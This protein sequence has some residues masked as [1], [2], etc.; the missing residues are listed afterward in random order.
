MGNWGV[1]KLDLN[2]DGDF[3][4]T[5][6]SNDDRTHNKANEL[7]ARDTDDNGTD[8]FT[9][10]FDALGNLTDDAESYEYEYDG[11]GRL[12]K[13]KDASDSS[14]IAE[15]RYNG[16]GHLTALHE[17][18]DDDSD[19]DTNDTWFYRMLNERW[20]WVA[21]IR[22][23]D[24][25]PKEEFVSHKGGFAAEHTLL[26]DLPI[27]NNRDRDTSWTDASDQDL[28]SRTF[29]SHNRHSDLSA[30]ISDSGHMVEW[31]SY[32]GFSDSF[33]IPRGDTDSDGVTDSSDRTNIDNWSAGYDVRYD[34]NLSGTIDQ[35][36]STAATD[37][38]LGRGATSS[39]G[40]RVSYSAYST[41]AHTNM[42]LAR[43]RVTNTS[44]GTWITRDPLFSGDSDYLSFA[45]AHTHVTD[46]ATLG[47]RDHTRSD[48][49]NLYGYVSGRFTVLTDPFGLESADCY[50]LYTTNS[51]SQARL[52]PT[53]DL[54]F[55][56]QTKYKCTYTEWVLV[57]E[58]CSPC[59]QVCPKKRYKKA[60]CPANAFVYGA[61][62]F[63]DC[64]LLMKTECFDN[65]SSPGGAIIKIWDPMPRIELHHWRKYADKFI[66]DIPDVFIPF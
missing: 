24:T 4:D 14:L 33:G 7:T 10:T 31:Y 32:R 46:I 11:F 45:S 1:A 59:R 27:C 15:Y 39:V 3:V 21:T 63:C 58:K 34:V 52:E 47:F 44:L 30:I 25:Y 64:S 36:D 37:L 66:P 2:G 18:T 62:P 38:T 41:L 23:G 22:S 26:S 55:F 9:L 65:L 19:V 28:E 8:D 17:D 60:S 6:E 20:Q 61:M 42:L 54:N 57:E 50:C 12:R 16:L 40:N 29:L 51:D 56:G 49:M 5:D 13:I 43:N 35:N 53:D 48:A